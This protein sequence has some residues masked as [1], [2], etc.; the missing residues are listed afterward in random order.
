[1]GR[2]KFEGVKSQAAIRLSAQPA[3]GNTIT[4]T[5]SGPG[6]IPRTYEFDNNA[7]VTPGNILVTIGVSV[8]ATMTNLIAAINAN[9]PTPSVIAYADPLNTDVARLEGEFVGAAGNHAIA[10]VGANITLSGAAFTGGEDPSNQV[11]SRGEYVVT[12][13]DVTAGCCM[14]ST[15]VGS[16]RFPQVE[17]RTATGLLKGLTSLITIDNSRI[18]LDFDGATNPAAGDKLAWSVWE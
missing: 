5:P 7:A 8:A 11:E 6:A 13:L 10:N 9:K 3:D 14:I 15:G 18:K 12:A 1:M 16:P 4:I 2:Q 17:C